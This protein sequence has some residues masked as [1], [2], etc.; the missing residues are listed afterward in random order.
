MYLYYYYLNED[1]ICFEK[2]LNEAIDT[3]NQVSYGILQQIFEQELHSTDKEKIKKSKYYILK[4]KN[5]EQNDY[6]YT[7]D[8]MQMN[9]LGFIQNDFNFVKELASSINIRKE[10]KSFIEYLQNEYFLDTTI[11]EKIFE[12][13]E[14]LIEPIDSIQDGGYYDSKL[15][16]EFIIELNTRTKSDDT[17]IKVLDL[18]DRFLLSET[19]RSNTKSA[20]E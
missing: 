12:L 2:L 11:A 3:N 4:F 5:D 19:L 16:I 9:G 20:I 18:I 17:K 7:I 10:L 6:F 15:L 8:L 1:K 13:L 14:K